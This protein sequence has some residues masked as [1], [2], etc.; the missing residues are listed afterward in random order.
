MPRLRERLRTWHTMSQYFSAAPW[1]LPACT[2]LFTGRDASVHGH[3]SHPHTLRH[4]TLVARFGDGLLRAAFVNNRALAPNSGLFA[5]FEEYEL[6]QGHA[7]TFERAHRF[8][9][10]R[11]RDDRAYFLVLHSNLVHDYYLASTQSHYADRYP[12]RDDWFELGTRVIRW[13]GLDAAQRA[14]VR[15]SYAACAAALDVELDRVLDRFDD[16]TLI[17]FVSDHGEG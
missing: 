10:E 14:T 8:L 16:E 17:L 13:E 15:R 6:I 4:P 7:E 5:D 2:T 1:T 12:E 9:D 3:F 11:A